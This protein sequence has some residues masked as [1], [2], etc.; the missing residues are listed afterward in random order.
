MLAFVTSTAGRVDIAVALVPCRVA[1]A[2]SIAVTPRH[3]SLSSR[4]RAVHHRTLSLCS[5]SIARAVPRHLG[6]VTSSLAV[7]EPLRRPLPSRSRH[8]IH[9]RREAFVLS[10]FVEELSP[11]P[12]P[13]T[14]EEPSCCPSPSGH[15]RPC[16]GAALTLVGAVT[17]I[18]HSSRPTQASCPAGLLR[19][20]SSR[21][22][23]SSVGTSHCRITY[24]ASR[25]A[26]CRVSSL[27]T[28]PPPICRCLR[29]SSRRR[30][31]V[32][33]TPGWPKTRKRN[34][35]RVFTMSDF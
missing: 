8:V 11:R 31:L 20:L 24:R 3:P 27:L 19:C 18:R 12:L 32:C 29:L 26:G 9:C 10:L 33:C 21:H 13:L 14:I 7:E 5:R 22:R 30:L 6:A 1:A 34:I 28:P 4:H 2:P 16:Q 25:P 17:N 15:R 35:L 23:L